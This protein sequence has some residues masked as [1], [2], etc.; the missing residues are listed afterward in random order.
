MRVKVDADEMYPVYF[1]TDRDYLVEGEVE[2]T[3]AEIADFMECEQKFRDWQHK[4][5]ENLRATHVKDIQAKY[6]EPEI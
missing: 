2:L 5:K 6:K 4:I 3:E 1:L